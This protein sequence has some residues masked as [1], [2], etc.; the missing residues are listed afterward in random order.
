MQLSL[1]QFPRRT[2]VLIFWHISKSGGFGKIL[3]PSTKELFF[4]HKNHVVSG[5]PFVGS[6]ITFTPV[7]P[8]AGK[9]HPQATKA[10]IDNSKRVRAL[11]VPENKVHKLRSNARAVAILSG[12]ESAS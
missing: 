10:V 4:L 12:E 3:I 5:E 9:V 1:P 6:P 11:D 2:G 7:P 8:L